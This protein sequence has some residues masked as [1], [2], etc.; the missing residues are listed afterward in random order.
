MRMCPPLA[1]LCLSLLH[2]PAA[3][4]ASR[5]ALVLQGSFY[6]RHFHPDDRHLRYSPLGSL[7]W[8]QQDGML[9]G[10]ALFRN[11]FGQ[12]SQALYAG[13]TWPLAG[14]PFYGKVVAGVVHGYRGDYKDKVPFNHGG[15]NPVIIPSLGLAEGHLR[16]EAML[17]GLNGVMLTAGWSFDL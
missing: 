12:F 11:S 6:N 4:P 13:R 14:T 15:F 10:G 5:D 9:A 8:R 3:F 2:A 16:A 7:E 17:L 1:L